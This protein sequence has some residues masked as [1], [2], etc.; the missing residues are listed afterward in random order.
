MDLV[1]HRTGSKFEHTPLSALG[2]SRTLV[3]RPFCD[4]SIQRSTSEYGARPSS[5]QVNCPGKLL[6]NFRRRLDAE[7]FALPDGYSLEYGGETEERAKMMGMMLAPMPAVGD[8]DVGQPGP[9]ISF[10]SRWQPSSLASPC[11]SLGLG[12]GSLW[13]F[14][15]PFGF[16]AIM[17]A[18]GLIGVAI[19]D[20]IVVLAA[21]REDSSARRGEPQAVSRV[22]VRSSRH[23]LST[24]VTSIAGFLPLILSGGGFWPPLAIVIAGGVAV[25]RSWRSCSRPPPTSY[26]TIGLHKSNRLPIVSIAIPQT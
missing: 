23:V 14:G 21:I 7:G 26:F 6:A 25:A 12:F 8:V 1:P 20:A 10:L 11:L 2:S 9:L 5:P 16:M 3:C 18:T 22:V 24:T 4:Y 15:F 19:N 13:L 17:G